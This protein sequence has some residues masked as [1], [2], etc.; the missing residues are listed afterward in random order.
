MDILIKY[1]SGNDIAGKLSEGLKKWEEN[2]SVQLSEQG[3]LNYC[4]DCLTK[5]Y[6][7][8]GKEMFMDDDV[9]S[10]IQQIDQWLK[11]NTKNVY[12]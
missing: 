6:V 9:D 1:C 12:V 10:L 5:P 2:G 7:F 11:A 4:G 8:I 3:C